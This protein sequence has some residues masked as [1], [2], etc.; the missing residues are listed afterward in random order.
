[1]MKKYKKIVIALIVIIGLLLI[2]PFLIPMQTYL[3]QAE[4]L[5][6]KQLGQPV[7]IDSAHLF[8]LP[9]PHV[10]AND[11]VLG[12]NQ[13]LNIDAL[14]ITP[15]LA[16][17]FSDAKTIDLQIN[18]PV[19]KKAALDFMAAIS[20]NKQ[21]V[22]E[23]SRVHVRHIEIDEL[24]L[25]W[26]DMTLPI[27][28]ADV[29]L[30]TSHAL[31][32]ATLT[33]TDGTLNADVI[34]DGDAQLIALHIEKWTLPADLP[35]LIDKAKFEMRLDGSQLA[36]PS[37][38]IAMYGGNI[39]GEANLNWVKNWKMKGKLHI[40]QL[41]VAQPTRMVSKSLYLSGNLFAD[42]HF[43]SVAKEAGGLSDN[44]Q[45]NFKFKVNNGVLHGLDLVK[46]ASLLIKQKQGGGETQF[47]AFT[48]NAQVR[49]KQYKLSNLNVQSGLL[50]ATGRVTVAPS[51]ALSGE[52]KVEVKNSANMVA[53]PMNVSGTLD[54]PMVFPTKSALIGG[55]L[56]TAVLPGAGTAAG[57]QAAEKAEKVLKGLFGD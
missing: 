4:K 36:I 55:A 5:A 37:I 29:T 39:A 51:K 30:S 54:S 49:G 25:V 11:I 3:R 14:V 17:L 19:I 32:F 45:T 53:I 7:S 2:F 40:D 28:N 20:S 24:Q 12:K 16:S 23:P 38:N 18:K 52:V 50:G 48:G 35:L 10:T 57:V 42:G 47:D 44:L 13:E 27:I 8:L 31:E 33:S 6:S 46:I 22:S 15:T 9:S 26:P 1:M 43:S 41:A 21:E 34:P 56:G